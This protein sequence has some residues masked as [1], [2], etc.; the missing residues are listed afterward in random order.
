MGRSRRLVVDDT[1][2]WLMRADY[3]A[4]PAAGPD[5]TIDH[6]DVDFVVFA[7]DGSGDEEF[8]VTPGLFY[9]LTSAFQ[10]FVVWGKGVVSFGAPTAEQIAFMAAADAS[11]DLS[12]F[13][14]AFIEAGYVDPTFTDIFVGIRNPAF[15]GQFDAYTTIQ[16]GDLIITIYGDHVD[17]A[18]GAAVIDLGTGVRLA[19]ADAVNGA[20]HLAGLLQVE[21]T[22]GDDTLAGTKAAQTI[23]GR[24][25]NDTIT[26]GEG[27]SDLFGDGGNDTLTGGN[28]RDRLDGGDGNDTI[29]GAFGDTI[30]GGA[31]NDTIYA[32]RGT[33]VAGGDGT[34]RLVIDFSG[35]SIP[36][37][38]T[39]P[40][41][42]DA[43]LADV[44]TKY[45]G[46]ERIDIIGSFGNDLLVGNSGAN[47]IDGGRGADVI[48]GGAGSDILDAGVGG[49]APEPPVTT[50]GTDFAGAVAIN[51]A[52]SPNAD[53]APIA[54]IAFQELAFSEAV[55]FYTFDVAAGG[56]LLVEN[57]KAIPLSN[58]YG[59][60]LFDADFN[61]VATN[62]VD[63]PLD[64][65]DLAAG[66]YVL[67]VTTNGSSNFNLTGYTKVSLSTATPPERHNVLTGGTG[68][69][70]FLVHATDDVVIEHAREGNDTIIA[71]LSWTL[72]D[73]V[74]N[75]TLKAG[76]GAINGAG[77]AQANTITGNASANVLDG[78]DGADTLIGGAGDDLLRGNAG[79]DRM[80][81]GTGN[82][83]YRVDSTGDTVI[84]KAGA[85]ID[86]I[87]AGISL[88]LA[89]NV[90]NLVLVGTKSINGT[91][92]ALA[93]RISGNGA[94][95]VLDGGGGNDVLIGGAG[96][97]T[98]HVDTGGDRV[99]ETV[100]TTSAVDAGGIDT[101]ISTVT[102]TL[103]Q[104]GCQFVENL[105]LAGT[106][107]ID[108]T[109]NDRA[110]TLTGNAN[111]NTLTGNGGADRLVGYQGNDSLSGGA[112]NDVL[113]A[114]GGNDRLD[115]G[116]GIDVLFGGQGADTFVFGGAALADAGAQAQADR[117]SDFNHN[118]HDRIDLHG[119]DAN[120]VA[121]GDQ[122][123]AFIGTAAFTGH[124]GQ[125]RIEHTANATYVVADI[126]GDGVGDGY[127]RL[128]AGLTLVAADFVL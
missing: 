92:N 19:P 100:T 68:S 12:T 120:T 110:N 24:G 31:G 122:A 6:G 83:T 66:R 63:E 91:G 33:T 37:A 126:A 42:K 5:G 20:Y 62:V 1:N 73:N 96:N 22:I 86:K 124:A 111:A 121:A 56:H 107:A 93:N 102:F 50:F 109:G 101:V 106:D 15:V 23:H 84:E 38:F 46:I 88:K 54:I 58:G 118:E 90:E 45:T 104:S 2:S 59:F 75:L 51:D 105:T 80:A 41:G 52:F 36:I 4:D 74:E 49:R 72:P 30:D 95:N 103:D 123:F 61:F 3:L 65:T 108:A 39:L 25:G 10:T 8:T 116:S 77:N 48:N 14:G 55:G 40:D 16:F 115:P 119:I 60:T 47:R 114:G 71:D 13:P 11:T 99:Y 113:I 76:A 53:A 89:A 67:E 57:D 18:G 97:D 79:S 17:V 87:Y 112:G 98:Y 82:D 69:D 43:V 21:G 117:I 64:V 128:A 32:A 81:G 29:R 78:G 28:G 7:S 44:G 9:D 85:G 27:A 70:T 34:D 94:A 35:S 26:A 127:I 125:L